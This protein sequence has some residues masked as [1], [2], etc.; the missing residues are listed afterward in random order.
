MRAIMLT[1]DKK[2]LLNK[3][4]STR[5]DYEFRKAV[6]I[7]EPARVQNYT[8]EKESIA[9]QELIF[10]EN[11]PNPVTF[12]TKAPEAKTDNETK[13]VKDPNDLSGK[14]LDAI[15]IINFIQQTTDTYGKWNM[16]NLGFLSW[17]VKDP[18]RIPFVLMAG[19]VVWTILKNIIWGGGI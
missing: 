10:F 3:V 7:L 4:N 2:A 12:E 6:Y 18:S 13:P 8:E 16:P 9:G 5:G 11:N 1:R 14:Y 15:V 17:F 19:A